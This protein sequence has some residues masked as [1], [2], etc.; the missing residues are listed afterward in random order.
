LRTFAYINVQYKAA[1]TEL[2]PYFIQDKNAK[3]INH[4]IFDAYC[5]FIDI[6]GFTKLTTKLMA[7]GTLGAEQLSDTLN[8]LFG[9]LVDHVYQRDGFIPYFAGDAFLA[10]FESDHTLRNLENCLSL[11]AG[12]QDYFSRT[13]DLDIADIEIKIG[14]SHGEVEWGICGHEKGKKIYYFRGEAIEK[15]TKAQQESAGGQVILAA[16]LVPEEFIWVKNL[17]NSRYV[18]L[19]NYP[20]SENKGNPPIKQVHNSNYIN[21]TVEFQP[22]QVIDYQLKGEF[23]E[24]VSVFISFKGIDDHDTADPFFASVSA[25]TESFS[26]YFKEIDFS[27][28]GG[29]IV[30]LFGAPVT[31]ENN[32]ERALEFILAL[33]EEINTGSFYPS[34][35]F[36]AGITNGLCF[37][38]M[39]GGSYKKQYVALGTHVNLAARL[40]SYSK[41]GQISVARGIEQEDGFV[42]QRKGKVHYK[43]IERAISTYTLEVKSNVESKFTGHFIGREEEEELILDFL[44]MNTIKNSKPAFIKIYGEAGIG[45]S[46]LVHEIEK[47][48]VQYK[49][50]RWHTCQADQILKKPF[51]PIIYFL[52]DYFDQNPKHTHAHNKENFEAKMNQ[53]IAEFETEGDSNN[54]LQLNRI[55]PVFNAMLGF[56]T[57]NTLWEEL[58]ARAKFNAI[59]K[60]VVYIF[61]TISRKEKLIVEFEDLHWFDES[62]MA[63][64]KKLIEEVDDSPIAIVCTSRYRDDGS[65]PIIID[66]Q[67]LQDEG[68]ALLEVDLNQLDNEAIHKY[69]EKKLKGKISEAFLNFLSRTTNGNPFY[70]EQI[71]E[72]LVESELIEKE[73]DEWNIKDE[74][75]SISSSINSILMARVDR[76]SEQVK[77]TVKTAAVIGREFE[78][79]VLNEVMKTSI[80]FNQ[81]ND[82]KHPLKEQIKAAEKGQIWSAI[83]ELKYIFK[84]SLLREAVYNMQLKSNLRKL[85]QMIAEAIEH[86]YKNNLS[87]RYTDLAFHFEEAEKHTKAIFYM[88]KAADFAR[89]NF[90]NKRSLMY[91]GKLKAYVDPIREPEEYAKILL[92]ESEILELIGQWNESLVLLREANIHAE[93]TKNQI[94]LGRTKNQLG[95]L[96][97]LQG[98]YDEAK[99][100]LESAME[101]FNNYNDEI[102]L[103]KA[104]GNLGDLF[105]RKADYDNA[106]AYFEKSISLAKDF[107]D[108][109]TVTQIVSNLGLTYMNQ[110]L[111]EEAIECQVEQLT[112]CKKRGDRNGMAILNTN[113]GIV[114]SEIN[115]HAKALPYF[116][117]GYE[118]SHELGNKQMEAIAIGCLGNIYQ[119]QGNYTKA[120]ELYTIDLKLCKEL[121]DKRG[122]AIVNGLL[123]ELL[124]ATGDFNEAKGYLAD[125]LHYS[126]ELQY[127]KGITKA[128]ISLGQVHYY[129]KDYQNAALAFS[130]CIEIAESIKYF[131]SY[132]EATLWKV[133][134]HLAKNDLVSA[135]RDLKY[136]QT[137]DEIEDEDWVMMLQ[138]RIWTLEGKF[139]LAIASI[140]KLIES[141]KD[142]QLLADAYWQLSLIK[143]STKAQTTEQL[144]ALYEKTPHYQIKLKLDDLLD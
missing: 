120:L 71:I 111:Y 25:L 6:V 33:R 59:I 141:T 12:I 90:Q 128:Y 13:E 63:F 115:D 21:S 37:T 91:Y 136:L 46:R 16:D 142:I 113:I 17:K 57:R 87:E 93:K 138:A 133:E 50:L 118:L 70:L 5:L 1:L 119:Q 35:K 103:F 112:L 89:K 39:L 98:D 140:E 83:N 54:A 88:K 134:L 139:D 51:N 143:H 26:G 3:A 31:F 67:Y 48:L 64:L 43:G 94:L 131:P 121:G 41:W 7:Q 92:R 76:L 99:F 102:G 15:A 55:R 114:Y 9:P 78:I 75:I 65:K 122:I 144:K 106:R 56:N 27:D 126:Q 60:S 86:L 101:I 82:E 69:S 79:P 23:R 84:H 129:E 34:L 45:K 24:V 100:I 30:I 109:F 110:S 137:Y 4:G 66:N 22:K 123:G 36:K 81:S 58:D 104:Y 97:V 29:V 130:Q 49:K 53:F 47:Q 127:Q 14:L 38:G 132:E 18:K 72:Y 108:T 42:F 62:T 74:D 73:E 61:K 40:M 32:V 85:H 52:K 125:Q 2:I 10:F 107:K 135:N 80:A 19:D 11:A 77:E 28:K 68:F 95:K 124:I 117:R 105:F 116:D 44:K 20:I 96:L 8:K